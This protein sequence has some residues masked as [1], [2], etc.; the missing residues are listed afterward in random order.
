M[1]VDYHAMRFLVRDTAPVDPAV[2]DE[3]GTQARLAAGGAESI[4]RRT[5]SNTTRS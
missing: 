5:R 1:R 2:T 4:R 3:G